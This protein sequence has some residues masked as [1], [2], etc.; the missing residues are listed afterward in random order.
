[1]A[2][3]SRLQRK[4]EKDSLKQAF[5]YLLFVFVL[6]FLLIRFGLPILIKMATFLGDINSS[7]QPLEKQESLPILAPRLDPLPLATAS[8]EINISGFSQPG[9]TIKLFLRGI[10]VEET[11]ADTNGEFRF[12]S[13]HLKD[14][15]NEIYAKANNNQGMESEA[16][17]PYTVIVDTKVPELT[18][19]QPQDGQRFFDKDSPIAVAGETEPGTNLTINN[20][21]VLVKD[22]GTFS[23]TQSLSSG[24][25]QIEILVR[26]DAG[27]VTKQTL[28]VNYTP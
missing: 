27:N 23:L 17:T 25:N 15:E 28:T 14:G 8:A 4:R 10:S 16:S 1:M 22:D 21:F 18:V 12:K 19:S 26:D 11:T 7:K 2:S 20:R 3:K 24:D 5:K 13:V 9:S 6:L